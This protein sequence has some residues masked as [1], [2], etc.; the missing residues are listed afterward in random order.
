[1][2]AAPQNNT[3]EVQDR[4]HYPN[5]A[6]ATMRISKHHQGALSTGVLFVARLTD[7]I[8]QHS[9][10]KSKRQGKKRLDEDHTAIR[11]YKPGPNVQD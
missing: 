5:K 6:L 8:P 9:K 1:M 3:R 7:L 10:P 2:R 4:T 11:V